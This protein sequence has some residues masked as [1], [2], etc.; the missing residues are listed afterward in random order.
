VDGWKNNLRSRAATSTFGTLLSTDRAL[1]RTSVRPFTD[2]QIELA[3]TF[4]G[5]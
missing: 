1:S 3:Q 2:K 5:Q 4:A